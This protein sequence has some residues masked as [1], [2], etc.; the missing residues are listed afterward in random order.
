MQKT[1]CENR[2][3]PEPI[4]NGTNQAGKTRH[5][6]RIPMTDPGMAG[7]ATLLHI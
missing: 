5:T 7:L 6:P 4:R 2:P 1:I 3:W